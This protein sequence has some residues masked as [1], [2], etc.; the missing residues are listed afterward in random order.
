MTE[1]A[2]QEDWEIRILP[3]QSAMIHIR[4]QAAA[5]AATVTATQ[6]DPALQHAEMQ[7]LIRAHELQQH[8]EWLES[9]CEVM[10]PTMF[11]KETV[12]D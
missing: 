5:F 11:G 10:L 3:D 1:A 2:L 7:S 8:A 6:A 12:T 4:T 9:V